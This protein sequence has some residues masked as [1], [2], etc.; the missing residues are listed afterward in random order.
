MEIH[1]FSSGINHKILDT[2]VEPSIFLVVC[3]GL[4]FSCGDL[5]KCGT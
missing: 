4:K 5:E 3:I 1:L 2:L